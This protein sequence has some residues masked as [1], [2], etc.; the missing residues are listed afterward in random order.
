MKAYAWLVLLGCVS[1][2]VLGSCKSAFHTSG[3]IYFNQEE[4]ERS[5]EQMKLAVEEQPNNA[6][7]Y[8]YL[9]RAYAELEMMTE[10]REAFLKAIELAPDKEEEYKRHYLYHWQVIFQEG[11][12]YNNAAEFPQAIAAFEKAVELDPEQVDG[13]I[14]LGYAHYKLENL[15]EAVRIYEEGLTIAGEDKKPDI[16]QS[17]AVIYRDLGDEA[18]SDGRKSTDEARAAEQFRKAVEDYSKVLMYKPDADYIHFDLATAYLQLEDYPNALVH[19]EQERIVHP[20]DED[21]LFRLASVYA[22]LERFEESLEVADKLV[23][24]NEQPQYQLLRARALNNLGRA[25]EAAEAI[26]RVE[27]LQQESG[28]GEGE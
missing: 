22:V 20:D 26:K 15:E 7:A 3:I 18:Y 17:L 14:N 12:D 6:E 2:L 8:L 9:G 13:Y 21:L 1:I 10:A 5:I 16:H 25:E 24:V 11:I 27:E 19:L 4:Y 28:G 23:E